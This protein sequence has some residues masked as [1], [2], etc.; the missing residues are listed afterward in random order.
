MESVTFDNI[1]IPLS[2]SVKKK[3]VLSEEQLAT[4]KE[5]ERIKKENDRC[6]HIKKILVSHFNAPEF[7]DFKL[8]CYGISEDKLENLKSV[9]K[10]KGYN[11]LQK[12]HIL[13]I[14]IES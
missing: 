11:V 9:I 8:N 12:N 6:K 7:E 13:Y 3:S 14:S 10:Q 5:Q 1:D 2:K 4:I